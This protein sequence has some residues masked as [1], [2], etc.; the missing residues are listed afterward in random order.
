MILLLLRYTAD[1]VSVTVAVGCGVVSIAKYALQ[2]AVSNRS[3]EIV[4]V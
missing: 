1:G 4:V 3:S 2:A